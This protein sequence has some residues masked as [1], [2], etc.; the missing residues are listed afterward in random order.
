ML[1]RLI[2]RLFPGFIA[3]VETESRSWIMQCR[4][5]GHEVSIWDYGGPRY[6]ALGRLY[7]QGRCPNYYKIGMLRVYQRFNPGAG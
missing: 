3:R 5:Y 6:R 7:R 1:R 4:K 2:K